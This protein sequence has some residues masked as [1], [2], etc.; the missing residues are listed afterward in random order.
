METEQSG[1]SASLA[2]ARALLA[3]AVDSIHK[4]ETQFKT[5]LCDLSLKLGQSDV[6]SEK[7]LVAQ[8]DIKSLK[9]RLEQ[10]GPTKEVESDGSSCSG[11]KRFCRYSPKQR[12]ARA[13]ESDL[14]CL[15]LHMK[16]GQGGFRNEEAIERSIM[17][18]FVQSV[19]KLATLTQEDDCKSSTAIRSHLDQCWTYVLFLCAFLDCALLARHLEGKHGVRV[20]EAV[21]RV[22]FLRAS[23]S[24]FSHWTFGRERASLFTDSVPLFSEWKLPTDA[25]PWRSGQMLQSTSST[26]DHVRNYS[27]RPKLI[28]LTLLPAALYEELII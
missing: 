6:A 22:A 3:Q 17:Q 11:R 19:Q 25:T 8:E 10:R 13:I 14:I 27:C 2:D 5:Q 15:M 1:I 18:D 24:F 23:T 7:T 21:M 20:N 26:V 4:I 12:A 9:R 28:A 16:R